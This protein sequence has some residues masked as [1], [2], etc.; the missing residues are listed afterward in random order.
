MT[1]ARSG[2][3]WIIHFRGRTSK[4][5]LKWREIRF[6]LLMSGWVLQEKRV[7]VVAISIIGLSAW[8]REDG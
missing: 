4:R 2:L 5:N 1:E 8:T 6:Q 7:V 3:R